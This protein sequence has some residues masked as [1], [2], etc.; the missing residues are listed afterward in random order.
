MSAE[1]HLPPRWVPRSSSSG[2]RNKTLCV[3]SQRN[4]GRGQRGKGAGLGTGWRPQVTIHTGICEGESADSAAHEARGTA[5]TPI[6][7]SVQ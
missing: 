3:E 7:I 5:C 1:S 2:H 4:E 6:T